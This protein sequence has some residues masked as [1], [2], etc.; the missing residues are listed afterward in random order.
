VSPALPLSFEHREVILFL[1]A[2]T[3]DSISNWQGHVCLLTGSF[4]ATTLLITRLFRRIA[5]ELWNAQQDKPT[6][7]K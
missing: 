3:E 1:T 7:K 2:I 4:R 6:L 5:T